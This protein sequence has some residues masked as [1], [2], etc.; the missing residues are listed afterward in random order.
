MPSNQTKPQS[1]EIKLGWSFKKKVSINDIPAL[2][3][4]QPSRMVK[5]DTPAA[6]LQKGKS[7]PPQRVSKIWH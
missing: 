7:P 6:S 4:F 5:S 1:Q 3:I 2:F